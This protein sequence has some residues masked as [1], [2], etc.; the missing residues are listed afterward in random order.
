MTVRIKTELVPRIVKVCKFGETRA[1]N[2]G[3][4]ARIATIDQQ[5]A[6]RYLPGFQ[7]RC[8]RI[9]RLARFST[10]DSEFM[11]LDSRFPDESV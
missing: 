6:E 7:R 4:C 9:G 11:G 5:I 10:D 3:D 8:N 1:D 2:E